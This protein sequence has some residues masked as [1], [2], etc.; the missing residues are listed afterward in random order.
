MIVRFAGA[1]ENVFNGLGISRLNEIPQGREIDDICGDGVLTMGFVFN[2]LNN[3][4]PKNDPLMILFL[5]AYNFATLVTHTLPFR[6]G[7]ITFDH[8]VVYRR[9][10]LTASDY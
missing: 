6:D 9:L 5:L 1:F 4:T 8:E 3:T 2:T 10:S 7:S